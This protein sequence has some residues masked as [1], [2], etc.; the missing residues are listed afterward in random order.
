MGSRRARDERGL[1]AAGSTR[2]SYPQ[3][4]VAVP[5]SSATADAEDA[6]SE[7]IHGGEGSFGALG[8]EVTPRDGN[9]DAG[10]RFVQ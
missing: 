1:A 3:I 7:A 6:R 2:G 10:L 4:A 5:I 8:L 9:A